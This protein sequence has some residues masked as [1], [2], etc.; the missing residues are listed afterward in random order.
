MEKIMAEIEMDFDLIKKAREEIADLKEDKITKRCNAWEN[1][2]G[3]AK[4]KE[5]FVRSEVAN[6]DKQIAY[7]EANVEY[8]Y[9]R[10]GWLTAKLEI[11]NE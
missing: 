3:T 7:K 5:D 11:G 4:E 6:L 8:L 1:A 10:I 9:N 2:T